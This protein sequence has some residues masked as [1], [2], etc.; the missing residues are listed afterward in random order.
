MFCTL[1]IRLYKTGVTHTHTPQAKLFQYN[2]LQL[3]NICR[4][5]VAMTIVLFLTLLLL[6]FFIIFVTL[7]F[8][9]AIFYFKSSQNEKLL[10]LKANF[11]FKIQIK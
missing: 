5:V 7:L 6:F 1:Y 9:S 4:I 2:S 11:K 8:K 10:I 3:T